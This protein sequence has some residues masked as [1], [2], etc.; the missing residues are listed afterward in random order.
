MKNRGKGGNAVPPLRF[1]SPKPIANLQILQGY[2]RKANRTPKNRPYPYSEEN[3]AKR[4]FHSA[5]KQPL[6]A[7][8]TEGANGN[9]NVAAGKDYRVLRS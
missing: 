9:R 1:L 2:Y 8:K 3:L 5:E 4:P 7:Q 6:L